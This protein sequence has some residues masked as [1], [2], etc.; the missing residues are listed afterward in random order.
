MVRPQLPVNATGSSVNPTKK[1]TSRVAMPMSSCRAFGF[2]PRCV[3]PRRRGQ[4]TAGRDARGVARTQRILPPALLR[5]E[6]ERDLRR[7]VQGELLGVHTLLYRFDQ[8]AGGVRILQR[9]LL[10]PAGA[11]DDEVAPLNKEIARPL[12]DGTEVQRRRD[13]HGVAALRGDQRRR[14][15]G[16]REEHRLS[17]HGLPGHFAR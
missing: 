3:G 17:A 16:G 9:K 10:L 4:S 6:V 8:A 12:G 1:P 7:V 2:M 11:D 15:V 5:R 13:Q 14:A